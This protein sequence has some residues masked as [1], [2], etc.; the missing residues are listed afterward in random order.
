MLD[1]EKRNW[2]LF[3]NASYDIQEQINEQRDRL[4]KI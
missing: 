4:L 3:M 1:V 2:I